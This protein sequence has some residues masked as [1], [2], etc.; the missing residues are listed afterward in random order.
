MV[1]LAASTAIRWDLRKI[2]GPSF[3]HGQSDEAKLSD[4]LEELNMSSFLITVRAT[5]KTRLEKLGS[6]KGRDLR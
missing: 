3:A 6:A 1:K 5:W 4:V 2:C